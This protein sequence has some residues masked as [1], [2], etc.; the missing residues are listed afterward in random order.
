MGPGTLRYRSET[1]MALGPLTLK[2]TGHRKRLGHPSRSS[3][4]LIRGRKGLRGPQ[5]FHFSSLK[6]PLFMEKEQ[7]SDPSFRLTN[8]QLKVFFFL[9]HFMAYFQ[10][11]ESD[12]KLQ[13]R[14]RAF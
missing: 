3:V 4:L 1:F 12:L 5:V 2:D 10:F 11:M 6:S 13:Y 9:F 14:L 8:F 7:T